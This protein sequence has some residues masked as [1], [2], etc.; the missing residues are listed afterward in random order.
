MFIK[1]WDKYEHAYKNWA[2]MTS[3]T[4]AAFDRQ[5]IPN[6]VKVVIPYQA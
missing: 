5:K 3:G 4:M 1:L 2:T 6:G